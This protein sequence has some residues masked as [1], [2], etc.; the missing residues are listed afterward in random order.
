MDLA[1]YFLEASGTAQPDYKEDGQREVSV[2][3]DAASEAKAAARQA[4]AANDDDPVE[5]SQSSQMWL[6][7]ATDAIL[8]GLPMWMWVKA[9]A[10]GSQLGEHAW[11]LVWG[12]ACAKSGLHCV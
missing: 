11:C 6:R 8:A 10:E 7:L 3:H 2:D 12:V 9:D 4:E 5:L 1:A